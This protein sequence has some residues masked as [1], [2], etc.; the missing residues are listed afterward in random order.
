[1]KFK[2][3]NLP[4][5]ISAIGAITGVAAQADT[6][7]PGIVVTAQSAP[8]DSYEATSASSASKISMPLR[9]LPQTL[10]V[11]QKT[12]LRDQIAT[13][14]QDALQ[15]VAGAS[16]SVGDGQRDQVSLRGFSA[17]SDQFIDGVRDDALYFRDLSNIERI[18]VL[19]GPASVLYGR[20]SAGGLINRISKKPLPQPLLEFQAT[21]GSRGQKRG[22]FDFGSTSN[23][24]SASNEHPTRFRITGALENSRGVRQQY[25]LQRQALAPAISFAPG[26]R[27]NLTLQ[28]DYLQDKR[29][30]D[31]GVPSFRGRPVEVPIDTYYGA[32]NGHERGFV[33]SEVTSST[34]TLDHGLDSGLQLHTVLR[35]YRDALDRN[36]NTVNGVS[37]GGKELANGMANGLSKPT[38]SLA[39]AHRLRDES[40]WYFQTELSQ[41]LAAGST[42][43]HLLYGLELGQQRKSEQLWVRNNAATY[44][45]FQP[46]LVTLPPLPANLAASADN[47]NR[48]DIAALYWQDMITFDPHWKM[49]AGLRL[50]QLQHR[51][52]DRT[53]RN[54]D[55]DRRDHTRSPRLGVVW[56]PDHALSLWL[57]G[58]RSFQPTADAFVL[59]ANSD[60]LKPSQTTNFD[61]GIK[62]DLHASASLNLTLFNMTQSGIQVADPANPGFALALGQQRT[63]GLELEFAGQLGKQWEMIS[64]Y[65]WLDGR[66]TQATE[67]TANGR[68]FQ[69][70]RSALTP[71]HSL[72]L[73][74]KRKLDH[75]FYLAAGCRA[76]SAR[77]ASPDNLTQLPGYGVINLGAGFN[78]AKLELAI[79]VKNLLNRKYFVA[80][81]GG[82]NDYN[83]PGEPLT[84]T[85]N[86]RY[87]F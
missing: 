83:L 61:V 1:M 12:V 31:Q 33:R 49:L 50:D 84:L 55:L 35:A 70:N 22:E 76:E 56:Q 41:K 47:R 74:L 57:A 66:I 26:P 43:H 79:T 21:L 73:W 81:H 67:R 75:G 19:K 6:A 5:L 86:L 37:D 82:A 29:L 39:Q 51:R 54:I 64:G 63:R 80:A 14:L 45:L 23:A 68:P 9:D 24:D 59:R 40:G 27:T 25:F 69:G 17:I 38:V 18:E 60:Q 20:G 34:L 13:S 16:A 4:F 62:L 8:L 10:N 7:L 71:R 48:I 30:A 87:R 28:A 15:N 44:D 3:Q 53:L 2:M 58:S 46:V 85:T 77:F 32:A 78:S 65:A 11:V 42:R 36:Y 72:N 52:D